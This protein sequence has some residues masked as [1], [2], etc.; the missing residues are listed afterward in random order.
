M[1]QGLVLVMALATLLDVTFA[2]EHVVGG[3]V[4]KWTFLHANDAF[5]LYNDWAANQTF[6]TGDTLC[7]S[8]L[9]KSLDIFQCLE[10]YRD[11][12]SHL[13]WLY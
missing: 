10:M 1:V 2:V 8:P 4:Q 13:C 3:G 6:K 11:L 5:T 12:S 7:R 9:T